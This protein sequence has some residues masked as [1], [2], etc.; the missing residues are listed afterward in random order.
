MQNRRGPNPGP[1]L[2]GLLY[3]RSKL[4][5]QRSVPIAGIEDTHRISNQPSLCI[6]RIKKLLRIYKSI[7]ALESLCSGLSPLGQFLRFLQVAY[8][9]RFLLCS[10]PAFD[11]GFAHSGSGEG[12]MSF[13]EDQG[14]RG[15]AARGPG[16]FPD[17]IL[18]KSL[19]EVRCCT[20]IECAGLGPQEVEPGRHVRVFP[21]CICCALALQS[22]LI[23]A[24]HC[25]QGIYFGCRLSEFFLLGFR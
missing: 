14:V 20:G 25:W 15:I 17:R 3:L 18:L 22:A 10:G 7:G 4:Y 13:A 11:L 6:A 24:A 1:R 8:D 23:F 5:T 9:K 2:P 16:A 12:G 19:V 21:G